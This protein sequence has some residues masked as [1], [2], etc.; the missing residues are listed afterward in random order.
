MSQSILLLGISLAD[1]GNLPYFEVSMFKRY[2]L[3]AL[4]VVVGLGSFTLLSVLGSS[5]RPRPQM[6]SK[7][8][9]SPRPPSSKRVEQ[10]K[11]SQDQ[12]DIFSGTAAP[13]SSP[14][15]ENQADQGKMPG[16]DFARDPP[17]AKR[18]SNP[19]KR[20]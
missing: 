11:T 16:F 6:P 2:S 3:L 15:L 9:Q 20:S 4:I 17:N 1:D 19:P 7:K 13:L 10:E 8:A 14:A 12:S 5:V 18:P